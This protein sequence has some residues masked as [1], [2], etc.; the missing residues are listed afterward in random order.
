MTFVRRHLCHGRIG[1][2]SRV[3]LNASR[4]NASEA[5]YR[6]GNQSMRCPRVILTDHVLTRGFALS[7]TSNGETYVDRC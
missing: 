7:N 1:D 3:L 4:V 2:E 6:R 5:P